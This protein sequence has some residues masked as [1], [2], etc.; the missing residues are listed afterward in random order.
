MKLPNPR[1]LK[2]QNLQLLNFCPYFKQVKGHWI[3]TE[4]KKL[5]KLK[6]IDWGASWDHVNP[7]PERVR[8]GKFRM[9]FEAR[10]IIPSFCLS[11]W[12]VCVTPRTLR[13]LFDLRDIQIEMVEENPKC[14]CKCGIEMRDWTPGKIYGGYFY[15]NSYEVGIERWKT[16]RKN[17]SEKISPDVSVILK[18]YCTEFEINTGDSSK[19]LRPEG[20]DAIEDMFW[21]I[22]EMDTLGITQPEWALL[23]TYQQWIQ[24]GW[25]WGSE[26]DRKQ[27]EVDHNE[28]QP[29]YIIPRT[30]NPEE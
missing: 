20:A 13:E 23:E 3:D 29:L 25:R 5:T 12:K 7:D 30:Y 2:R 9:L 8:C 16:V 11:C 18:R 26:E 4:T 15:T 19:Y 10:N 28:G 24:H 22:L 21:H 6:H 1:N 27:I 14:W 17:V